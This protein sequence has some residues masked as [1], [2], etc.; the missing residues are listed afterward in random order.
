MSV[1]IRGLGLVVLTFASQ[2]FAEISRP[3]ESVVNGVHIMDRTITL[4]AG[5]SEI[6][7]L[8]SNIQ[9]ASAPLPDILSINLVSHQVA[10]IMGR[11]EGRTDVLFTGRDTVYRYHVTVQRPVR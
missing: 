7:A 9:S 1:C 6:V 10:E 2:A 11:R 8:P 5:A 4:Q 3:V